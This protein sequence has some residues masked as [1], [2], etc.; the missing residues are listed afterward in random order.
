MSECAVRADG[1]L[2]DASEIDWFNNVDND[3][4]IPDLPANKIP[5]SLSTTLHPFFTG[6][7]AP[8]I[9]VA[10]TRR[11]ARVSWPSTKMLDPN[12]IEGSSSTTAVKCKAMD[13]MR[14]TGHLVVRKVSTEATSSDDDGSDDNANPSVIVDGDVMETEDDPELV[15]MS[16]KAMGDADHEVNY[17]SLNFCGFS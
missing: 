2:K 5:L 17:T 1:M 15:Y 10:G 6:S 7:H 11:S 13:N 12:N 9:F 3:K 4:P 14:T 8:A 16:T